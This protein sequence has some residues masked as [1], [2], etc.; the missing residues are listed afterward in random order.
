MG[1]QILGEGEENLGEHSF[2]TA[3]IAYFLAKDLSFDMAKVLVMSLFHDFHEARTGDVH[4]LA[5]RY[6]KRDQQKANQ[7]I[8][9]QV[10]ME[11]FQTI[12]EYEQRQTPEAQIVFEANI[13]ALLVELKPLVERGNVHARE[14]LRNKSRI[15]TPKAVQLANAVLL[16]DSQDW[17]KSIRDELHEEYTK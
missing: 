17:W 3:I 12:R 5:T 4:K 15:R 9:A 7:D 6:V 16:A 11:L 10:D 8:F 13:I 1:F 2:L 14:W